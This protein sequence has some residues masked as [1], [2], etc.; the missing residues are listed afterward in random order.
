MSTQPNTPASPAGTIPNAPRPRRSRLRAVAGAVLGAVLMAGCGGVDSETFDPETFGMVGETTATF[1]RMLSDSPSAL[2]PRE[3]IDR[4]PYA[5]MA[6]KLGRSPRSL[7]ILSQFDRDRLH[8]V[9]ADRVAIVTRHGRVVQ[10]ASLPD[11]IRQTRFPV[12]DPIAPDTPF[13][14]TGETALRTVDRSQGDW[15]GLPVE[16]RYE[17]GGRERID[18]QGAVHDTRHV[19][20]QCRADLVGWRF[21]NEFWID[22]DTGFVWKSIQHLS[23]DYRPIELWMVRPP[24]T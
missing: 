19:I 22:E 12:P 10:T 7:L 21:T 13:P 8:W 6:A 14:Q 23:P 24:G 9:S 2:P 17:L 18:L 20:E 16:C 3:Q 4:I 15:Y 1:V 5:S 11:P